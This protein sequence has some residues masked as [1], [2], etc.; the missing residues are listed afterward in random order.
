MP[1]FGDYMKPTGTSYRSEYRGRDE[2]PAIAHISQ[3]REL[4]Q[5]RSDGSINRPKDYC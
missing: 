3:K 4:W 2:Q 1:L 5:K